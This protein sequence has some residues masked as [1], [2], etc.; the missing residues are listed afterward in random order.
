MRFYVAGFG[1]RIEN[2][3]FMDKI[4]NHLLSYHYIIDGGCQKTRFECIMKGKD[5]ANNQEGNTTKR[6]GKRKRRTRK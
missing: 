1:H 4:K 6:S 5:N 2:T 3:D